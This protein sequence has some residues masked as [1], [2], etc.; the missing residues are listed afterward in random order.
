[1]CQCDGAH[2]QPA[3]GGPGQRC[4]VRVGGW[5]PI[6]SPHGDAFDITDIMTC[7]ARA[8]GRR[9]LLLAIDSLHGVLTE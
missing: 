2:Y 8:M 3:A 1:M 7:R 6:D 4:A 9:G 5:W